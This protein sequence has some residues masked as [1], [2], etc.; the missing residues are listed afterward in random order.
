MFIMPVN[1]NC[2]LE[3]AVRF[4]EYSEIFLLILLSVL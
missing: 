4:L 1:Y 3:A 2:N